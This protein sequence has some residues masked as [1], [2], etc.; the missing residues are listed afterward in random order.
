MRNQVLEEGA[1]GGRKD[2]D[3]RI[4][5]NKGYYGTGILMGER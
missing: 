5:F 2:V 1:C 4:Y 3:A